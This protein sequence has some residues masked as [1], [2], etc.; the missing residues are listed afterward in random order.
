LDFA[1]YTITS[2]SGLFHHS[3]VG[4]ARPMPRGPRSRA[5]GRIEI[6]ATPKGDDRPNDSMEREALMAL[7]V[8]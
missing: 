8:R 7:K 6:D 1:V 5:L 4:K 3:G 2:C